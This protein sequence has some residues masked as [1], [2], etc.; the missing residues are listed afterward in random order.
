MQI[1]R[2]EVQW[3]QDSGEARLLCH[4]LMGTSIQPASSRGSKKK[5][6]KDQ[7]MCG[8]FLKRKTRAKILVYIKP[9]NGETLR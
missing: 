8:K 5:D 2:K 3:E 4:N 9:F 1:S 6:S 7:Q